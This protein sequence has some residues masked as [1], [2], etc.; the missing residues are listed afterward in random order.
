M[1]LLNLW[2]RP[3]VELPES[4]DQVPAFW[5]AIPFHLEGL[6]RLRQAGQEGM[7]L[8]MEMRRLC[9]RKY[10]PDERFDWIVANEASGVLTEEDV[11]YHAER[12]NGID[13]YIAQKIT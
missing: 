12:T 1:N 7:K 10:F 3:P 5:L 13:E 4:W 2:R 8:W 6:D 9:E 11:Q